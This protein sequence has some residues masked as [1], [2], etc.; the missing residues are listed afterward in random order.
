[1]G[2]LP[3]AQRLNIA[4]MLPVRDPAGLDEFLKE[5]YDPHSQQYHQFLTAEEFTDR[6]GPSLEDYDSVVRFA[7]SNGMTVTSTPSN[8]MLEDVSA[9]VSDIDRALHLSLGVYQDKTKGRTFFAP[10]REPSVDLATPLWH[11]AGLN[12]FS[13]PHPLF[14]KGQRPG[15]SNTSGSGP[16]GNFLGSDRRAAYYGGSS[17]TGAGQ[18]VGLVEFDGYNVADV[19]QYFTNVGQVLSVPTENVAI[20]GASTGSDGDD[21]EQVIDIVEAVSIAPGL[22]Q[23]RVYIALLSSIDPAQ[24]GPGVSDMFNQMATDDVKQISCS[25]NWIPTDITEEDGVFQEFGPGSE[26]LLRVRRQRLI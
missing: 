4:I 10:D 20:D 13:T 9:R 16:S 19:Q 18:S 5:L 21:T 1:M 22:S 24:S 11:I 25:W 7:Q 23:V 15:S 14:L 6:F 12:N 26:L 8:R 17:L 3:G 2:P